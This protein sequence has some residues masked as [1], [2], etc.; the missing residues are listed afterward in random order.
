ML[1]LYFLHFSILK[2]DMGACNQVF[3]PGI[4]RPLHA[5]GRNLLR[6]LLPV[7]RMKLRLP[8]SSMIMWNM[9]L[10]GNNRRSI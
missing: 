6:L 8:T 5:I 4:T 2:F 3:A 7:A 9:C 1:C 10:S